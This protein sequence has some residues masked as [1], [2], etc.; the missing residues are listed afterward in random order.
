MG[1]AE[2]CKLRVGGAAYVKELKESST[3]RHGQEDVLQL[4]SC[5]LF[6]ALSFSPSLL[7]EWTF[8]QASPLTFMRQAVGSI[9]SIVESVVRLFLY[10]NSLLMSLRPTRPRHVPSVEPVFTQH[11]L[12]PIR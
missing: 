1:V 6:V 3:S 7:V 10:L 2:I 4:V 8:Q 5:P 12:T 11:T 9:A